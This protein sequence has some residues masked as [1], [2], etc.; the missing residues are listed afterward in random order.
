MDLVIQCI[1]DRLGQSDYKMYSLLK[2]CK[3]MDYQDE[4]HLVK[5]LY[6][7]DINYQNLEIQFKT[8]APSIKDDLSLG[9]IVSYLKTLYLLQLDRYTQKL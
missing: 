4:L 2:G 8:I 9:G 7:K 5:S 3:Q 1:D 6:D